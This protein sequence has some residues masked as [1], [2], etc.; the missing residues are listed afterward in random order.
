MKRF[1]GQAALLAALLTG[2][3]APAFGDQTTPSTDSVK[4]FALEWFKHFQAGQIDRTQMTT[5][6]S[7]HLSDEAV[8]EMSRYLKSHG[9]ATGDEI[10]QSR[11]PA[12]SKCRPACDS[13][14]RPDSGYRHSPQSRSFAWSLARNKPR[15]DR[16]AEFEKYRVGSQADKQGAAPWQLDS[17]KPR[18]N[19]RPTPSPL[20]A[21]ETATPRCGVTAAMIP[22]LVA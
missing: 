3:I 13:A 14:R 11:P 15:R 21:I 1:F 22:R 12:A 18:H 10:V 7:E 4:T 5:A 20:L 19:R 16:P 2:L 8:K 6:F 9:P 17:L